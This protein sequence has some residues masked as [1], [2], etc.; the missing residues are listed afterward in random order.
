MRTSLLFPSLARARVHACAQMAGSGSS[1]AFQ[2]P[3]TG[4]LNSLVTLS[5]DAEA[6][7]LTSNEA[8]GRVLA[9][10]VCA[11]ANATCGSFQALTARG[12]LSATVL[13]AGS[14]AAAFTV[15]ARAP[16]CLRG[17]QQRLAMAVLAKKKHR[18]LTRPS[19]G[20]MISG[21]NLSSDKA[22]Q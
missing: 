9:A 21:S 19:E 13:N 7:T 8:P 22:C 17:H 14:V 1:L 10:Q 18:H 11:F 15:T 20:R 5:V 12:Y 2:L 3:V 4:A 6:L 16:P